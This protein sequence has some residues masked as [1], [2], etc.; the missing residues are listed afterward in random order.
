[1]IGT[2]RLNGE[3]VIL[4]DICGETVLVTP[5]APSELQW[6]RVKDLNQIQWLIEVGNE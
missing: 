4:L 1:M 5:G 2:A 6:V 3:R